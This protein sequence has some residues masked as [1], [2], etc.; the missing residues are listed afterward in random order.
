[1]ATLKHLT[2]GQ[3]PIQSVQFVETVQCKKVVGKHFSDCQFIGLHWAEVVFEQCTFV[4]CQW[5]NITWA[6]GKFTQCSHHESQFQYCVL[7]QVACEDTVFTQ[8]RFDEVTWS[9]S[10]WQNVQF[11]ISSIS[12]FVAGNSCWQ[13]VSFSEMQLFKLII[14]PEAVVNCRFDQ[15][16]FKA[17][18]ANIFAVKQ[19]LNN[20]Y[21]DCTFQGLTLT[22]ITGTTFD[23][24][25]FEE[26]A[27]TESN[28]Q[29]CLWVNCVFQKNCW[30]KVAVTESAFETCTV[31]QSLWTFVQISICTLRKMAWLNTTLAQCKM[32]KTQFTEM[33][34][35]AGEVA[36]TAFLN[37]QIYKGNWSEM[38]FSG[39]SFQQVM[40]YGVE[41]WESLL[42]REQKQ[43]ISIP[44]VFQ[45]LDQFDHS[46]REIL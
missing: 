34:L 44:P 29:R 1:M 11:I 6:K 42:S 9:D 23:H 35:F 2:A 15:M 43:G 45:K 18:E 22:H 19:A 5:Q 26:V 37:C 27:F 33:R 21:Y 10:V 8:S 30:H 39:S 40:L 20:G 24:C 13:Q 38:T 32:D 25:T 28:L 17:H 14:L 4:A 3:G 16:T 36:H 46:Q 31:E 41:G 12:A 7:N